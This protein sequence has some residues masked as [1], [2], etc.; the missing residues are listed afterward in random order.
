M[1]ND[2]AIALPPNW[3]VFDNAD[4]V[5]KAACQLIIK[6]AEQAISDKGCFNLVTAGGTTPLAIYRMLLSYDED[7]TLSGQMDWAAWH[8]YIGDERCLPARDT[9]RNSLALSQVWLSNSSIPESNIHQM[10][11][12]LGRIEAQQQFA[13]EVAGVDFDLVMLGMG[14]DGHTASLFPSHRYPDDEWIVTET[15]SP[16]PPAERVS[17]SY[18]ALS[19]G[20]LVLKLITGQGK[21]DAVSAWLKGIDL[22][23]VKVKGQQDTLVYLSKDSLPTD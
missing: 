7:K 23:I 1:K 13:R 18:Q 3:H 10:P 8:V 5:A 22:P 16:K 20:K 12:E 17:L 4:S 6:S 15:N 11:T 19:S 21:V 14:E 2:A 9:E